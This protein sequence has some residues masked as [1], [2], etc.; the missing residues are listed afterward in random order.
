VEEGEGKERCAGCGKHGV[1]VPVGGGRVIKKIID[2]KSRNT[3]TEPTDN[4]NVKGGTV[5]QPT[6]AKVVITG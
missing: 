5:P 6:W 4:T 3:H 2:K 1:G